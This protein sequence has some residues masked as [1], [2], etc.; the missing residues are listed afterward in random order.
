VI[1]VT[2][3]CFGLSY[4]TAFGLEL[5]QQ[6]RPHRSLR[7]VGLFAGSAGAIAHSLF[8]LIRQPS[9]AAP[10]GSLLLLA[11]VLALFYLYGRCSAKVQ[12][13]AL[14]VLPLVILFVG[15]SM[16]FADGSGDT[17]W[18]AGDRFW[19][20]VHGGFL[21]AASVGITL[22]FLA[23]LM[24][25][26]QMGRLRRKAPPL[27]G[28]RLFSLEHLETARQRA[29]NFAVPFLTAGLLLG[30]MRAYAKGNA[31]HF[32][33][34]WKIVGSLLLWIVAL[35]L[36]YLKYARYLP[37]RRLAWLTILTFVMLL[38]TLAATHPFAG[39]RV[40]VDLPTEAGEGGSP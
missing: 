39:I 13:W 10:Y 29:I 26:I 22:A 9:P 20:M 6:Y 21:M 24:Y 27:G 32:A 38:G 34:P 19:G 15:V 7:A 5:W 23:S 31:D 28:L 8:L 36:V 35:L 11:W 16:F 30:L 14:F 18:F 3:Y 37:G 2:H 4:L 25:L 40:V 1:G 33:G 12:P 17:Q